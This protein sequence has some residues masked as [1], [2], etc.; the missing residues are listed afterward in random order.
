MCKLNGN[1]RNEIVLRYLNYSKMLA[2]I[3]IHRFGINT[4][5]IDD[6]IGSAYLGLVIASH[7]FDTNF[8]IKFKTY[9]SKLIKGEIYNYFRRNKDK[10]LTGKKKTM[11]TKFRFSDINLYE[12]LIDTSIKDSLHITAIKLL[13][14]RIEEFV[15]YLPSILRVIIYLRYYLDLSSIEIGFMIGYS[16]RRVDQLHK[17]AL[18]ELR[19]ISKS[20]LC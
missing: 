6:Y 14:K 13:K 19:Q 7:N 10:G 5:E 8:G 16:K 3:V 17:E 9:A 11:D 12:N 2:F 1:Q 4:C 15:K 18:T 20:I